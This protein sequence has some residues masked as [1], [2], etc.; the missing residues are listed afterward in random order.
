MI[1]LNIQSKPEYD[2]IGNQ[3]H[4]MIQMFGTQ[5]QILKT[6][7]M[8][9]NKTFGEFSH[10][11]VNEDDFFNVFI[12]MEDQADYDVSNLFGR[13]GLE[14]ANTIN[15]QISGV[16]MKEVLL[17]ND[18]DPTGDNINYADIVGALVK[19]PSGQFFKVNSVNHEVQGGN[20]LFVYASQK[21]VYDIV[22]KPYIYEKASEV[23]ETGDIE[24]D[25]DFESMDN[26]FDNLLQSNTDDHD[27]EVP[28]PVVKDDTE[29]TKV[30]MDKTKKSSPF[31][32]LG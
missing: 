14:S 16:S 1:N 7:K 18:T 4:D 32:N 10:L 17:D 24:T 13:F 21:N 6:E 12:I 27:N 22:L 23:E 28:V 20:N 5:V 30:V 11:K 3:T 31:G 25:L 29:N 2:L 8:G 15:A 19:M 9:T 26:F